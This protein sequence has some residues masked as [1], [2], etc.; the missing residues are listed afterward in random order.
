MFTSRSK[1][2]PHQK[3]NHY[4]GTGFLTNKVD[5]AT[6]PSK[7]IPIA[8]KLPEQYDEFLIYA[9]ENHQTEFVQKHNQHRHIQVKKVGD[10]NNT[11]TGSF[12]QE[13]VNNPLL[14][15]GR[16]FDIGVYTVITS[17]NPLRVYIYNGEILFRYDGCIFFLLHGF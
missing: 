2:K 3:V 5:L 7:Y 10:I 15:D 1:L 13:F 8:F 16:K 12:I 9:K 11:D 6:T 17:V 4:P 14:V